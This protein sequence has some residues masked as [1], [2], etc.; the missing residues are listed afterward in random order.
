VE[1][2]DPREIVTRLTDDTSKSANFIVDL[3][4][5]ELPRLYFIIMAIIK[6]VALKSWVLTL[7]LICVIPVIFIGAWI[8]KKITFKNRNKIQEKIALL[9]ARLAEKIDK[10]RNHQVL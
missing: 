2:D 6:V 4:A 1:K 3:S 5:N 7:T 10:S 9:T 8:S